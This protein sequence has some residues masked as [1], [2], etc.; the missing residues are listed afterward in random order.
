MNPQSWAEEQAARIAA[1][2]KRLRRD[3][4]RSAQWIADRTAELGYT[5]TRPVIAD[6]ESG[7][8]KYVTTAELMALA[9]ALNTTPIALL[10]PDPLS[11]DSI[12]ILPGV[13]GS[14]TFALQ[15]F[16][17]E[18]DT[19]SPWICDDPDEYR[20]NLEPVEAARKVSELEEQKFTLM[21]MFSGRSE[22]KW[23]E[24][25][26]VVPEITRIQREIDKLRGADGG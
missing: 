13:K 9:R 17:G 7:R 22:D 12:E 23:D 3:Q 20:G 21:K 4:G 25:S 10:Y 2:V 26:N 6:L 1:E 5:V 16:S 24:A 18:A 8:R 11:G 14:K 15:W 19:P